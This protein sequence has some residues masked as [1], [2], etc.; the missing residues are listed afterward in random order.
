MTLGVVTG[1]WLLL[2]VKY[3]GTVGKLLMLCTLHV[4][5]QLDTTVFSQYEYTVSQTF[6]CVHKHFDLCTYVDM[7]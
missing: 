4:Y 3:C 5:Y 6:L 2:S 1:S 7:Q